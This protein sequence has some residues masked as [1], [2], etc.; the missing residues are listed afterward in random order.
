MKIVVVEIDGLR[1]EYLGP[2]GSDTVETP[3]FN[4]LAAEG[5]VFD[6]C[7]IG[8]PQRLAQTAALWTGIHPSQWFLS[9]GGDKPGAGLPAAEGVTG[10]C[11]EALSRDEAEGH[12]LATL[13][14]ICQ[15][16]GWRTLLISP[17]RR[18]LEQ[19][20]AASFGEHCW[21][22]SPNGGLEEPSEPRG[23]I[24]TDQT[25]LIPRGEPAQSWDG[26]R[27]ALVF[28][29]LCRWLTDTDGPALVW[30]HLPDLMGHWDAPW[31][32]RLQRQEEGDPPPWPGTNVPRAYFGPDAD[33]DLFLPF[34]QAYSAQVEVVDLCLAGL[35]ATLEQLQEKQP[36]VVVL[37]SPRGLPLGEH[38]FLGT[39][40]RPLHGEL[41]H[42]P[43]I[44]AFSE[45]TGR[46]E[47]SQALVY[48]H[49]VAATLCELIVG[50]SSANAPVSPP[51][52]GKVLVPL[53]AQSLLPVIRGEA[54]SVRDR[55]FCWDGWQ[56]LA[57]RTAAWFAQIRLVTPR[58]EDSPSEGMT[59]AL[60]DSPTS[61]L[62]EQNLA[63]VAKLSEMAQF[64]KLATSDP[65]D[66]LSN[67]EIEELRQRVRLF[68]KPDDRWEVNE[69][70]DRC[71]VVATELLKVAAE[72]IQS[73]ASAS[74]QSFHR[75]AIP[76]RP[77]DEILVKGP[78]I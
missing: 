26:T 53:G 42:V 72:F 23:E 54:E 29:E 74:G 62:K 2:Y 31:E 65:S 16:R 22:R 61:T 7:L 73:F 36:W 11:L 4:R 58:A 27:T 43:L 63:Q 12:Q 30:C 41:I 57:V 68:V 28:S 59:E 33:P 10:G 56:T 34:I 35:W 17:H 14:D 75:L 21:V 40:D 38:G 9:A 66:D 13:A 77:L 25:Q 60:T 47:R 20:L 51:S 55:L 67:L 71:P 18:F 46:S 6:H 76:M 48:P 15:W 3:A 24:L 70:A 5:F 69:V 45:G 50:G 1:A 32:M 64:L 49:D 44:V 19:P 8:S 78:E 52:D 37:V 39:V